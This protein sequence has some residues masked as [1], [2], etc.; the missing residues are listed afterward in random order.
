MD[1]NKDGI[2]DIKVSKKGKYVRMG[3]GFIECNSIDVKGKTAETLDGKNFS[4]KK[5][6]L[7]NK[8]TVI[9]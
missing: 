1:L 3:G 2:N 5:M 6:T 8:C 9:P 7:R 4:G